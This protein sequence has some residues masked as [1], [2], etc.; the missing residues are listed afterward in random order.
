M[1]KKIVS[2]NNVG[3]FRKSAA[4]GD[5]ALAKRT[6]ILGANGFGK[7]TL[8]A[9]LRSLKTGEPSNLLGR[10]TLGVTDVPTVEV[11]YDGAPRGLMEPLG[12][13]RIPRWRFLTACS[14]RIMSIPAK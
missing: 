11:L 8:C 12:R 5:T 13:Q 7:T 10:R 3:K 14:S 2:V 9:V 4:G 6:L 1:L